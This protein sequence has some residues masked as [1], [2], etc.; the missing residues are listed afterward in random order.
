MFEFFKRRKKSKAVVG[1]IE[2]D[3]L[4]DNTQSSKTVTEK[5]ST[6]EQS[7]QPV[8]TFEKPV[9]EVKEKSLEE[10][11]IEMIKN[12]SLNKYYILME[13]TVGK[14]S[15]LELVSGIDKCVA[16][17]FNECEIK[18]AGNEDGA[19]RIGYAKKAFDYIV[20]NVEYDPILTQFMRIANDKIYHENINREILKEVSY[21]LYNR[22]GTCL[23]DSCVVAY[24]FEKIGLDATVIGMGNHA[25]VEVNANG[26]KLYCDSVYERAIVKGIDKNAIAQGKGKGSGFMQDSTLMTDRNYHRDFA[27]PKMSQLFQANIMHEENIR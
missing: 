4:V 8:Y 14:K 24:M 12:S 22:S 16:Q 1:E 13:K 10:K 2:D 26:K 3:E 23:A 5:Q 21:E 20:N 27:F 17:I 15:A 25:M 11:A 18:I 19:T 6:N 7:F 9:S